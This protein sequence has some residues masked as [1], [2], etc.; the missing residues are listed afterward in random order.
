MGLVELIRYKEEG[1]VVYLLI[2]RE[3]DSGS[4]KE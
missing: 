4:D 2:G 3:F 1:G